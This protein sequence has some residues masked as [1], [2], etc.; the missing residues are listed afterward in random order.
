MKKLFII[1]PFCFILS[2]E[3]RDS[4]NLQNELQVNAKKNTILKNEILSLEDSIHSLNNELRF[5]RREKKKMR[6]WKV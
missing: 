2:C 5:F 1:V 4:N 3:N 6:K